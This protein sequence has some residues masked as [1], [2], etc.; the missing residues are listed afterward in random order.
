MKKNEE[1][2]WKLN[3]IPKDEKNDFQRGGGGG[4]RREINPAF[5]FYHSSCVNFVKSKNLNNHLTSFDNIDRP[6]RKFRNQSVWVQTFSI[7]KI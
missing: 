4:G 5:R 7:L 1:R 3:F 2:G 6:K